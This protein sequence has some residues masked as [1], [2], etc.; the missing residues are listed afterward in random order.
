[1]KILLYLS[2]ILPNVAIILCS[3]IKQ[4][5]TLILE[6]NGRKQFKT[7]SNQNKENK[8]KETNNSKQI[9]RRKKK[10]LS[11]VFFR[12]SHTLIN[13]YH[14]QLSVIPKPL[15]RT[16]KHSCS[17]FFAQ[18]FLNNCTRNVSRVWI[19]KWNI[20]KVWKMKIWLVKNFNLCK[21]P[22]CN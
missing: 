7:C 21:H 5:K 18:P 16:N 8:S 13:F 2:F 20:W 22:N 3:R 15:V 12:V 9:K 4:I 6:E 17:Y 14:R 19:K 11:F 10:T 1:M